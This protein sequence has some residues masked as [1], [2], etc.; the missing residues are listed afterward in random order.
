MQN[1]KKSLHKVCKKVCKTSKK[2]AFFLPNA[3]FADFCTLLK[4][5]AR[6]CPPM[7]PS[8]VC[9]QYEGHRLM[10][11]WENQNRGTVV[12]AR[13]ICLQVMQCPPAGAARRR[14]AW[15]AGAARRSTDG[16]AGPWR[17]PRGETRSCN[18]GD[19]TDPFIISEHT[20]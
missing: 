5:C 11:A 9:V 10:T 4:K 13:C 16:A 2:C 7:L 12:I 17:R 1:V 19:R 20:D 3:H 8:A 15:G 18:G 6:I 14:R